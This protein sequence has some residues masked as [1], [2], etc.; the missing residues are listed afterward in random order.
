[1]PE[2]ARATGAVMAVEPG[3]RRGKAEQRKADPRRA[4]SAAAQRHDEDRRP[5]GRGCRA[6]ARS[7]EPASAARRDI[8]EHD[9]PARRNA[10]AASARPCLGPKPNIRLR[11]SAPHMPAQCRLLANPSRRPPPRVRRAKGHIRPLFRTCMAALR[12]RGRLDA[13]Q[14][15]GPPTSPRFFLYRN[16]NLVC[17]ILRVERDRPMVDKPHWE[18]PDAQQPRPEEVEF[19]LDRRCA[20]SSISRRKCPPTPSPRRRSARSGR[21]RRRHP[22]HRPRADDRLSRHRGGK[23]HADRRSRPRD[24]RPSRRHRPGERLRAGA[25]AGRSRP[26]G[27]AAGLVGR[28]SGSASPW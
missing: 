25:G 5:H 6:P 1:M 12:L 19:D 3:E 28:E 11:R 17:S 24:A 7:A 2:T 13:G 20:R 27:A 10:P 4:T 23:R 16:S 26:A 18:V 14:Y 9:R 22:R 15:A 21:Q 8:D